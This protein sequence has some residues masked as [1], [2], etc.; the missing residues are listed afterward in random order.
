MAEWASAITIPLIL[1]KVGE[2]DKGNVH[3]NLHSTLVNMKVK[4]KH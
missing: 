1:V 3:Q 2:V 4:K